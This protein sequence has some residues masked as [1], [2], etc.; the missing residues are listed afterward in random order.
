MG[1]LPGPPLVSFP[2]PRPLLL[3]LAGLWLALAG[4]LPAP[5]QDSVS[6][7]HY[8]V[9]NYLVTDRYLPDEKRFATAAPKPEK[10]I[11]AMVAVIAKTNPDVLHVS[12]M[13]PP[14]MFADFRKRLAAAGLEYPETEYVQAAD[15]HRHLAVVSRYPIVKRQSLTDLGF[16]LNGVREPV[17]RGFLDVTIRVRD[18]F[19]IRLLGAHLKSRRPVPQGEAL[20]RRNESILLRRHME[21]ILKADPSAPLVL[22]GDLNDT[23]DQPSIKELIGVRG[24]PMYMADLWLRDPQGDRWTHY[25]QT[26]DEY[27]R[28]DYILVSPD[29]FRRIDFVRSGIDRSP[30]WEVASDHRL[31][32]TTILAEPR[33]RARKPATSSDQDPL[34]T[35]AAE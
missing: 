30:N 18:G 8:N 34:P 20:L 23:K 4:V 1:W 12:E 25:W 13:G 3:L 28:I 32:Y 22:V 21:S 7:A 16:E 31:I 10:S 5:G 6:V 24:S 19:E 33:K 27:S 11:A 26:A 29:V 15:P 2:V 17:Q 9:Q 14:E 35:P